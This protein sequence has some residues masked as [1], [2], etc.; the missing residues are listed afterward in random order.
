[1]PVRCLLA[2]LRATETHSN[3]QW[4]ALG[5]ARPKSL[6]SKEDA[7]TTSEEQQQL[8]QEISRENE[9]TSAVVEHLQEQL[10]NS[11]VL[12]LNYKHYHWQTYGPLF[13]DLHKLF[14][15]LAE[16]VFD[17]IDPLAERIRM[18]G[19]DPVSHLESIGKTTKVRMAGQASTMRDFVQEANTNAMIMIK[20]LREAF[21]AADEA[22][23]PGTADLLAKIV[24]VHE[25]HEW[26]LREV[27]A[28][29]D[30]LVAAVGT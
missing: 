11:I 26:F 24:Q 1:M 15:D 14:D 2:H 5:V 3:G 19:Q 13:R 6:E 10:A 21:H 29:G 16:E 25:K 23:D 20:H 4:L 27:L 22:P 18:I 8:S 7:V 17:T 28:K 9:P 30:G 12:W